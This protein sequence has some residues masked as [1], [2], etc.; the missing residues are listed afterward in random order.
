[1]KKNKSTGKSPDW[2]GLVMRVIEFLIALFKKNKESSN[3]KQNQK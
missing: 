2:I 1:M 3:S